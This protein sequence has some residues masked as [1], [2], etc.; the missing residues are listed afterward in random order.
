MEQYKKDFVDLLLEKGGLKFGSFTLKSG[1]VSPYFISTRVIADGDT[2]TRLGKFYA[3]SIKENLG[4]G[5][6][7]LFRVGGLAGFVLGGE[8]F[9]AGMLGV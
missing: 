7:L 3:A 2:V 8:L 6:D 9:H 1:R 5:F 4:D